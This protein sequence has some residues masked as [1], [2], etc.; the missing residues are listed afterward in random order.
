M[1]EPSTSPRAFITG[2]SGQ[3]GSFLA[4]KLLGAGWDVH[5]L[6]R[7]CDAG[8]E[9]EPGIKSHLGDLT[10]TAE[11]RH[12]VSLVKP[13]V[14]FNLAGLSSVAGSWHEPDRFA[15]T[16]GTAV[17]TLLDAAFKVQESSGRQVAFVQAC[18]AEI[19]GHAARSP[20]NEETPVR[21]INPYGAAK[22]YAHHMVGIYRKRGLAA[23]SAILYNHES[24]RRPGKFVTRKIT[25]QVAAIAAGSGQRLALGNLNARRDWGWAPDF[26]DAMIQM[27]TSEPDDFVIATG[28]S[29]TVRDFVSAS[30]SSVGIEDWERHVYIDDDLVR[31]DDVAEMRGDASKARERLGWHPTVGFKEIVARMTLHDL[32]LLTK[33]PV[34]ATKGEI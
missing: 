17:A 1:S 2:A 29:H 20:Q 3:D 24:P 21:P 31:P 7:S 23:S 14:V 8:A 6:V 5:A 12:V 22:A 4:E 11:L 15:Q 33:T 32:S 13:D 30:F 34:V 27:S 19:F 26:V 18:S 10:H 28:I 16:N 9:L 25:S